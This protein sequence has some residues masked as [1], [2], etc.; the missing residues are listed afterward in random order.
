[1]D[2]MQSILTGVALI[3]VGCAIGYVGTYKIDD[4]KHPVFAH[5]FGWSSLVCIVIGA[6][7][8]TGAVIIP[9]VGLH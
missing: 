4:H 1:M 6:S 8:V 7:L 2:W 3:T 9:L 5:L